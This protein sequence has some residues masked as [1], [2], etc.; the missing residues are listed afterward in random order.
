L[1]VTRDDPDGVE[2][3]PREAD[4]APAVHAPAD[5]SPLASADDTTEMEVVPR[6]PA[7]TVLMWWVLGVSVTAVV[8]ALLQVALK[9]T[10]RGLFLLCLA[11]A[12][13][14]VAAWVDAATR[15]IP[16]ILTYP[17]VLIGIGLHLA[18][19][20][21]ESAGGSAAVLW[22]GA[23]IGPWG[24][25]VADVG[26]RAL[27]IDGMIGFGICAAIGIVSFMTGG[28]GGGDVK[29]LG[30]MG[31][32]LGFDAVL[33]VLF[34]TLVVAAVV[35]LINLALNGGLVAKIQ[36]VALHL[37]VAAATKKDFTKVYPF[38]KTE[39]PF[40]ISVLGGLIIAQWVPLYT[41]V[42]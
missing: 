15:R 21:L 3:S 16:N 25:A 2:P 20:A 13:A 34:N 24:Q 4:A 35:G 22:I 29:L 37:L 19:P 36:V 11:F 40:G 39:S 41:F 26:G 1:P 32:L 30:A 33:P 18:L 28:L 8:S 17:A 27:M 10:D 9:I 31:A 7:S 5:E 23:N 42:V 6:P 38:K 14:I 12:V